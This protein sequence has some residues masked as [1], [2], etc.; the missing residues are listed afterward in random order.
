[1]PYGLTLGIEYF[2]MDDNFMPTL[3]VSLLFL[4]VHFIFY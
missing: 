1:L 4:R 3:Q 2:G